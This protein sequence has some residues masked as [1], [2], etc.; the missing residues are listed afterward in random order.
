MVG[1]LGS[2]MPRLPLALVVLPL[3]T[4]LSL[5]FSMALGPEGERMVYAR[6]WGGPVA[7][8][9]SL[10]IQVIEEEGGLARGLEGVVVS[11]EARSGRRTSV[12]TART[13]ADGFVDV[14][15]PIEDPAARIELELRMADAAALPLA[16]GPIAADRKTWQEAATRSRGIV[17]SI[18]GLPLSL[19]FEPPVWS[20]PFG[21]EVVLERGADGP[22]SI[23]GHVEALGA[24][25]S[26]PA[27]FRLEPGKAQRLRVLP[28]EHTGHLTLWLRTPRGPVS[29]SVTLPIRPGSL[30]AHVDG[31]HIVVESPVPR[32][33]I[34]YSVVSPAGRLSGGMVVLGPRADGTAAG[35]LAR[36][37]LPPGSNRY[38]VLSSS[39]DGRAP[40]RVGLPLDGQHDTFDTQDLLLLDGRHGASRV[41]GARHARLRLLL[42]AYAGLG[43][44]LCLALFV[45]HIRRANERLRVELAEV[46]APAKARDQSPFGL[47]SALFCLLFAFGL[48]LT[49]ILVR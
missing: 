33:R 17:D 1:C 37:D 34:Y 30:A 7:H 23:E 38:L 35:R 36:G 42:F 3:L 31:D 24:K 40:A 46:G 12:R 47:V 48:A 25:L 10:R 26:S 11:V 49:W 28:S 27:E 29:R 8:D 39:A 21:G 41:A 4:L 44:S 45:W 9:L 20:A 43:G 6:V 18:A 13:L 5:A 22:E 15:L 19:R 32:S 14:A 2:I 16:G